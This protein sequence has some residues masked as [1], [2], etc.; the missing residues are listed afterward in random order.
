MHPDSNLDMK[1]QLSKMDIPKIHPKLL[2]YLVASAE[3]ENF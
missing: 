2:N 3:D 1:K